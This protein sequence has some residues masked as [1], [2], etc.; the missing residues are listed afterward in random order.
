MAGK[1]ELIEQVLLV[2]VPG[3]LLFVSQWVHIW[4]PDDAV[5]SIAVIAED[6]LYWGALS[7]AVAWLGH[8]VWA[9]WFGGWGFVISPIAT[10]LVIIGLEALRWWI[11]DPR[12]LGEGRSVSKVD[13]SSASMYSP[14]TMSWGYAVTTA[15]TGTVILTV[16]RLVL[17][18]WKRSYRPGTERWPVSVSR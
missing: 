10:F 8:H 9:R 11:L 4:R 5:G 14:A 3:L 15:L 13:V 18:I 2:F 1:R 16:L 12:R 7:L 17:E 6:I